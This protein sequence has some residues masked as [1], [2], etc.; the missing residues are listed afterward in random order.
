VLLA[1]PALLSCGL[2]KYAARFFSLPPGYYPVFPHSRVK[3]W[4]LL[5]FYSKVCPTF[6]FQ[7][8]DPGRGLVGQ[9]QVELVEQ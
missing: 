3:V 5:C 4:S 8:F 1:L 6:L 2:L 7:L 9:C